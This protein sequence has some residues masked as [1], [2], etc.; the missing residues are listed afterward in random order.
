MTELNDAYVVSQE[1]VLRLGSLS[2]RCNEF[3][4]EAYALDEEVARLIGEVLALDTM[5]GAESD[6]V[7]QQFQSRLEAS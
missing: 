4:Q 1:Q 3:A 5:S 2:R 7:L 6:A